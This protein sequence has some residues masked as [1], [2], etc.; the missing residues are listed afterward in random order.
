MLASWF[1]PRCL[2]GVVDFLMHRVEHRIAKQIVSGKAKVMWYLQH[3]HCLI[4]C[5]VTA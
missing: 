4:I 3:P 1:E 2:R 5:F